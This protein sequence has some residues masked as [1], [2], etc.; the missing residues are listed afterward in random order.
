LKVELAQLRGEVVPR[1]DQIE[2]RIKEA[3][4]ISDQ[5]VRN[6]EELAEIFAH[7]AA[8]VPRGVTAKE[9]EEL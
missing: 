5:V 2:R 8:S 9:P 6:A 3:S 4:K 1:L 7:Y